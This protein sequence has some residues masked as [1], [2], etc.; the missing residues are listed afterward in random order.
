MIGSTIPR[1]YDRQSWMFF[2]LA[3][4]KPFHFS[5]PFIE[6]DSQL[7]DTYHNF[8]FSDQSLFIM[9]NW[10]ETHECEDKRDEERLRKRIALTTES[11]AMTNGLAHADQQINSNADSSDDEDPSYAVTQ[12]NTFKDFVL[13]QTI[14]ILEQSQWLIPPHQVRVTN[15]STISDDLLKNMS[16]FPNISPSQLQQWTSSIKNQERSIALIRQNASSSNITTKT[17]IKDTILEAGDSTINFFR[18]VTTTNC[19]KRTYGR[20]CRIQG[21]R[22]GRADRSYEIRWRERDTERGG[23]AERITQG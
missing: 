1:Q 11:I 9:K 23:K 18:S 13:L 21:R 16:S 17:D 15:P 12:K 10:E 7:H 3:H 2:T 6:K 20:G 8:P 14:R 5:L 22:T 4:F 19:V